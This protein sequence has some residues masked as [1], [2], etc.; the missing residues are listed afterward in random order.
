MRQS[1][2]GGWIADDTAS[3]A[4]DV[5]LTFTD[6]FTIRRKSRGTGSA[7]GPAVSWAAVDGLENLPGAISEDKSPNDALEPDQDRITTA[8]FFEIHLSDDV[9]ELL[10]LED[11]VLHD[12]T[13]LEYELK[14]ILNPATEQV[15]T[16]LKVA[17]VNE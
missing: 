12:D 7:S 5:A 3:L 9:A 11:R 10:S 17:K 4:A 14:A 13:G 6:T 8:S 1:G 15:A 2:A 16:K